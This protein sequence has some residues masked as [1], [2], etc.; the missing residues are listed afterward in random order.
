MQS[1]PDTRPLDGL[2]VIALEHA[3][4]APLCTRQL[5]ELGARVIKIERPEVGDFARHY[6]DRARGLSSHF[7]WV[8]RSKQSLTL[9]LKQAPARDILDKLIARADVFVQNLAPGATVKLGLDYATLRDKNPQLIVCDISGYGSTGPQA[10]RKAYDLLIQAE[11]GFL[12]I[13]GGDEPA[14]SGISIADIAAG[15]QAHS[16][17]LAAL[18]QRGKTQRGSHIEI[19]MLES[20]ADWMGY[21]LY[22]AHDGAAPPPRTGT[23]HASIYPYGQFRLGAEESAESILLGVQNEREWQVFCTKIL[24]DLDLAKDPQFNSNLRRSTNRV[25]LRQLIESCFEGRDGAQLINELEREGIACAKMNTLDELW[26]H[27]QLR[28]LNR[29]VSVETEGGPVDALLP[30]GHNSE[31]THALG[32]VPALG[33]DNHAILTEL[34][35]DAQTIAALEGSAAV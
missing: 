30:P 21:P 3:I 27:P 20:M 6:D 15:T 18:L 29:F 25:R 14:K 7:V 24:R 12:G 8:N 17:I 13:T 31:Y 2:T 26:Q 34:G 11:A 10:K 28:A 1:D 9:D 32:P 19:S 23:D 5:A 35:F 33:A 22:F 4:A 16:A